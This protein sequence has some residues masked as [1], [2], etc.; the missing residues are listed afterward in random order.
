MAEQEQARG[1]GWINLHVGSV[2]LQDSAG[3][4]SI[5]LAVMDSRG[6]PM[7]RRGEIAVDGE[8][9]GTVRAGSGY[10]LDTVTIVPAWSMLKRT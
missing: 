4:Q 2:E 3:W 6:K 10:V 5:E 9:M 7:R 8:R 1:M